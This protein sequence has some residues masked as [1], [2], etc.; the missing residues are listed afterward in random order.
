[1][2]K[3]LHVMFGICTHSQYHY[4]ICSHTVDGNLSISANTESR[5]GTNV[6]INFIPHCKSYL[7][8]LLIQDPGA[9][10]GNAV[11]V[12]GGMVTP[13]ELFGDLLLTVYNDG[14]ILL[15]H[16]DGHTVPPGRGYSKERR[17]IKE[18]KVNHKCP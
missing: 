12:D 2:G 7:E 4:S 17:Q 15:L 5:N 16:A 6:K 1:M 18:E 13:E 8:N 14:D 9:E 10:N 3:A 11:G